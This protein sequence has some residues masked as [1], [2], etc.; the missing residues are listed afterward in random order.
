[1]HYFVYERVGSRKTSVQSVLLSLLLD[2]ASDG[3]RTFVGYEEKQCASEDCVFIFACQ[4]NLARDD[5]D[6]ALAIWL[7]VKSHCKIGGGLII[8]EP[9]Y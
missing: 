3:A 2:A 7:R 9:I 6:D 1:V 4:N 5:D 8:R